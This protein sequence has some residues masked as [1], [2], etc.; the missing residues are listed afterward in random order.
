M[1]AKYLERIYKASIQHHDI[2]IGSN[3]DNRNICNL[4]TTSTHS[5][6]RLMTRSIKECDTASIL[7][8][9]I[10]CTDM[11]CDTSGLTG[12]NIS[13]TDRVKQR[14]LTMVNMSHYSNDWSAWK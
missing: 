3:N 1:I 11:L 10:V 6:K 5:G 14:S 4:C 9:N 8:L 7:K 12:D 2:V 13:L